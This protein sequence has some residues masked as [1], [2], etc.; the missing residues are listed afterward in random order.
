MNYIAIL[1][2]TMPVLLLATLGLWIREFNL[3]TKKMACLAVAVIMPLSLGCLLTLMELLFPESTSSMAVGLLEVFIQIGD[4]KS[5]LA[6]PLAVGLFSCFLGVIW[7]TTIMLRP[8]K[9]V[10]SIDVELEKEIDSSQPFAG[11]VS[12]VIR[13]SGLREERVLRLS[14]SRSSWLFYMGVMFIAL[15]V[16]GPAAGTYLYVTL[17]ALPEQ[18]VESLV[19]IHGQP[20][21]SAA[22][23]NVTA[24]RDW[25]LILGGISM[26]FLFL[27]TATTILRQKTKEVLIADRAAA[28]ASYYAR[29]QGLLTLEQAKPTGDDRLLMRFAQEHLLADRSGMTHSTSPGEKDSDQ[30]HKILEELLRLAVRSN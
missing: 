17:P 14:E 29:V 5:I 23:L 19:K 16:T 20:G 28:K 25:R 18:T 7:S 2:L 11:I 1:A 30:T 26:G 10:A 4:T 24:Q 12:Q 21:N 27:G 13:Q 3:S 15:S 9:T 6:I 8:R 22:P